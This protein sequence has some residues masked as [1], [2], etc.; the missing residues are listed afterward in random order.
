[1]EAGAQRRSGFRQQPS[2]TETKTPIAIKQNYKTKQKQQQ[3]E[4]PAGQCSKGKQPD[5][6][7][8][9]DDLFFELVQGAGNGD[10]VSSDA[11]GRA[12][13][14]WV[15]MVEEALLLPGFYFDS[16][17][18]TLLYAPLSSPYSPYFCKEEETQ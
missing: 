5:W 18:N 15:E 3:Q 14:G 4:N 9:C 12:V 2:D 1:M 17:E 11:E 6:I 8:A 10:A 16:E 13:G 7:V